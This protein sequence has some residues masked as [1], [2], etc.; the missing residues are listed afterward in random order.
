MPKLKSNRGAAKRFKRVANGRY[1]HRSTNRSHILTKK[2]AK[3]KGQLAGTRLV[4]PSD[5]RSVRRML[6]DPIS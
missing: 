5:T 1:K 4:D 3:R 2:S 6:N